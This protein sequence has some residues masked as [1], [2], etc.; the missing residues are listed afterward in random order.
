MIL[1]ACL[2]F[3]N[4]ITF[5]CLKSNFSEVLTTFTRLWS[6]LFRSYRISLFKNRKIIVAKLEV[7]YPSNTFV[8]K[9]W[10]IKNWLTLI[11]WNKNSK[12][13]FANDK[14]RQIDW[15]KTFNVKSTRV[16]FKVIFFDKNVLFK[17]FK[18]FRCK[19]AKSHFFIKYRL[20]A[21]VFEKAFSFPLHS[22]SGSVNKI[23]VSKLYSMHRQILP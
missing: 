6:Y 7:A 12:R 22:H 20:A 8:V 13:T 2:I 16:Y 15:S 14:R 1:V 17:T 9:N 23:L 19:R 5:L 18:I 3:W 4:L 10:W 11:D 21:T